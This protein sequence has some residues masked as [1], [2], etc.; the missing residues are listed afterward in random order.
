MSIP[1]L[2]LFS[3]HELAEI[4]RL[5]AFCWTMP[6]Q[7]DVDK[8][9]EKA[10]DKEEWIMIGMPKNTLRFVHTG[11]ALAC[12]T[13][14]LVRGQAPRTPEQTPLDDASAKGSIALYESYAK[15][16]PE[17]R[18]IDS[19]NWDLLHP[20][21]TENTPVS[22][23]PMQTLR[24]MEA[25]QS[26]GLEDE[27]I[28]QRVT[29][30]SNLP[31]YQFDINKAILAGTQDQITARLTV[32][33]S[34]G[35]NT[36]LG[37]HIIKA[38][39]I[40]DDDFGANSLGSVPFSCDT[41]SA[42]CSFQWKAPSAD[43]KY[44]GALELQVTLNVEGTNDE[45]VA[46][47]SFYSSPMVAGSFNGNFTESLVNGSLVI[48]A[49][50]DVQ[51]RM[52]CFVSANLY[53]ADKEAPVQFVQRRTI[54][55]PSMKSISFTFFGKIFRDYGEEGMFRIQDI[56]A[57]CENLPYPPE[58]FMDSLAHRAELQAFRANNPPAPEPTRI[59]FAYN[60]YSFVTRRYVTNDF[61]DEEWQ[62]PAKTRKLEALR[63]VAADLS[64]PALEARKHQ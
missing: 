27:E 53:S 2:P 62:S 3:V 7:K 23:I 15:Y 54:V 12:V 13:S 9:T 55:D 31:S 14:S 25:L 60:A 21:L 43:K 24:Q 59:Y 42:I 30:P 35:S 39:L 8:R 10:H 20:W 26:S 52:A 34:N 33:R 56:K 63:K 50:V 38:E 6:Q 17:S 44:W 22:L 51:R 32:T 5:F 19:S 49:G 16:P 61:S 11:L 4:N 58:W 57:Q 28:S 18:P 40:G 41:A 29:V 46:R 37:I 36:P 1:L 47:Q 45:Y 64:D 48:D